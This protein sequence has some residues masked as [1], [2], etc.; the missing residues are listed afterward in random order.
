MSQGVVTLFARVL[1]LPVSHNY[2][3]HEKYSDIKSQSSAY[4]NIIHDIHIRVEGDFFPNGRDYFM[5]AVF[6]GNF[7]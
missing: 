7:L 1:Y 5:T 4:K 2:V 3:S 6:S